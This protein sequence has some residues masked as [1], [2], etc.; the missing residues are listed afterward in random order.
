MITKTNYFA[1]ATPEFLA[2]LPKTLKDKHQLISQAKGKPHLLESEK[3]KSVFGLYVDTINSFLATQEPP[4]IPKTPKP[5]PRPS[6][7]QTRKTVANRPKPNKK[8][9][10][11][12]SKSEEPEQGTKYTFQDRKEITFIKRYL[13]LNG[14]NKTKHQIGLFIKALQRSIVGKEIRRTSPFAEE[15]ID[16]QN[17]LVDKYN[18]MEDDKLYPVGIADDRL[19]KLKDII[20]GE[21]I[22]KTVL[23]FKRFIGLQGKDN[24]KSIANLLKAVKNAIDKKVITRTQP[25]FQKL[26]QIAQTLARTLETGGAVMAEKRELMGLQGLVNGND[27]L[28]GHDTAFVAS[29]EPKKDITSIFT[30]MSEIDEVITRDTFRLGG[31]IGK[32]LGD[33]EQLKLAITIESPQGGGK[34]RF[35]YQ[36]ADAFADIGK[37]TAIFSLEIPKNSNLITSMRDEYIRPEHEPMIKVADELPF[38]FETVKMAANDYDVIIIDSWNKLDVPSSEFDKLKKGFPNT[39]FVVIFQRTTQGTIRGGTAPLFDSGINIEIEKVGDRFEDNYA[40]ATKNRYAPTGIRY[41]IY[42]QKII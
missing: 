42:K 25:Y 2:T 10:E 23:L 5:Q 4:K 41:N 24:R 35:T 14:K 9:I 16:M 31:E 1:V 37:T 27:S 11:E 34:T 28:N 6:S 39:I 33:L 12:P 8:K 26:E 20:E 15:I 19:T 22:Y 36:M 3:F 40:V 29:T 13:N 21:K 38:G 32:L 17:R 18:Q 30:P 7:K